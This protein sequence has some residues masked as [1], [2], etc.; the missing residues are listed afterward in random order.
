MYIYIYVYW[1][2]KNICTYYIYI[3]IYSIYIYIYSL[4]GSLT[5]AN[6]YNTKKVNNDI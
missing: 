3:Y 6:C 5:I 1:G 4:Y 2:E